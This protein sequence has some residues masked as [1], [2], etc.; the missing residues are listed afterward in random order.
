MYR[1]GSQ[2]AVALTESSKTLRTVRST[3]HFM[4]AQ[5][6]CHQG[7]SQGRTCSGMAPEDSQ[8][9]C[10][11]KFVLHTSTCST[12]AERGQACAIGIVRQMM[13]IANWCDRSRIQLMLLAGI[14]SPY[15]LP[16]RKKIHA[17]LLA[18]VQAIPTA[19]QLPGTLS[20]WMQKA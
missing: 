9:S 18:G 14:L 15:L 2:H 12:D 1:F 4:L 7:Q 11:L 3:L 17:T 5:P 19:D 20:G 8:K 10:C 13:M 6:R 16:G